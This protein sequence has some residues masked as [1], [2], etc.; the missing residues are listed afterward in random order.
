M[1]RNFIK[2]AFRNLAR[3]PLYGLINAAGLAV[4][5]CSCLLIGLFVWDELTY[6]GFE[7]KADRIVRVT[8]EYRLAGTVSKTVFTGTKVGPQFKRTFPEVESYVRTLKRKTLV[9]NGETAFDE[10]NVLYADR[11]FFKDF[12]FDLLRGDPATALEGPYK[13]VLTTDEAKKYFGN[14]E[15]IGKT[16]RLNNAN[17]YE[18]TGIV[19]DAPGNSQIKYAMVA[20]FES[21]GVSH[22]E[23]WFSANYV[24]Y[25]LVN[26]PQNIQTLQS[27][28]VS[29]MK[30]ILNTELSMDPGDYLTYHLEPLLWVHLH[31][32]VGGFEPNGS[33]ANVTI[34]TAIA[35]LILIIACINYAN[36]ATARSAGR[37]TEI[38]IR[39]VLGSRPRQIFSQFI[40]ESTVVTLI[41][42]TL[43]V[44][45]SLLVLPLFNA[46]AGKAFTYMAL[47]QPTVLAVVFATIIFVSLLA[48]AY[49]ALLLSRMLPQHILKSGVKLRT[50]VPFRKPLIVFQFVVSIF[51]IAVATIILQQVNYIQHKDLGYDR[52]HVLVLPISWQMHSAYARL[53]QA[54][55]GDRSVISV[56]GAYDDPTSIGWSDEISVGRGDNQKGLSIN[57]IPVDLDFLKTFDMKIIAG[58]DFTRSDFLIQ[59]TTHKYENYRS[60]YMINEKAAAELGWTP[61]EA[62]G[63][64]ISRGTPGTVKAVVRNF[65]FSS[66]H[67]P[68]GPL[69]IFLD[70]TMVRNLFL[71]VRGEDIQATLDRLS[72]I[73]KERVAVQPFDYHFLNDDFD[74][75]YRKEQRAA[76]VS[77]LFA[78]IAVTLAC[79]GL[80]ALAT[81]S[82][83][84]RTKEIG[85]RKVMGAN[86]PMIVY[87]VARE[88]LALVMVSIIIATPVSWYAGNRWLQ[89]FAYHITPG[90][91]IFAAAALVALM[92]AAVSV[93]VQAVRAATANPVR[94]L[95]YE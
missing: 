41:A 82:T 80:F 39:K 7:E 14:A 49:P 67:D 2:I 22:T 8:M 40:G 23:E 83:Q 63:K 81:Y 1:L 34:L 36:L 76:Q 91:W 72:T 13:I 29:Y 70:T 89:D 59:D 45:L 20:S 27:K 33:I 21:L 61:E 55:A 28:V 35:I 50:G 57:A 74:R 19:A 54:F 15:P 69:V 95:H 71:R 31:S 37:G 58:T 26:T 52:N 79:L 93:G 94:S 9:A 42:L 17:D 85:I 73:W 78:G 12:S 88:F 18:V 84:Q 68:I 32:Q 6:D 24:T 38:G 16:L 3:H 60:T 65:N 56:T 48:G 64:T 75:L 30:E 25:L 11:D 51:L 90:A 66:L 5:I 53:K 92:I 43:A 62:V 86:V 44:I 46:I 4:G 47:L 77:V 10:D 87:L